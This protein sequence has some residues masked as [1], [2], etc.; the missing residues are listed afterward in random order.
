MKKNKN[1]L[2]LLFIIIM[3]NLTDAQL[4]N[5][6][7]LEFTWKTDTSRHS[8]NLSEITLVLPKGSFPK[9]DYP[10]FVGK[11][12]G[13]ERFYIH[14]P[15][16][17]VEIDGLAK[18]YPLNML[19]IHEISNDKLGGVPILATYCPLCNASVVFDRRITVNGEEKEL[20]FEVSGMLRKS[21]M[22]M[23]D[24][25]T[26]SLWQQFM[27]ESIVGEFTGT[28]L[29]VIPS[30]I[31]SLKSFFDRYPDG[32]VLS[33]ETTDKDLAGL[34][35]KNHY[36]GY[37]KE[38][39]NPFGRYFNTSDIDPRLPAMERVIDIEVK[40]SRKIYP[41]SAIAEK[42]VINDSFK[43][44]HIVFFHGGR[45][46]SVLDARQIR[47][48]RA[49]GSVTAFR[50]V[51]GDSLYTFRKSG[52]RFKDEQTGST[53]DITGRCVKGELKGTLLKIVPHSN[54]FAFAWLAF[55]PDSEIY[56]E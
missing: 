32:K 14:E 5:P 29:K 48:S 39:G 19:T 17:A 25:E 20:E 33:N 28:M 23:L 27:G 4:R 30:M 16:I 11:R 3:P 41:F 54:H 50:P 2:I 6:K 22:V 38:G 26:E 7:K 40:G 36:V 51:V 9:I 53:W 47:E 44:Y 52:N 31:I 12:W 35:G 10:G 34:Y 8:V 24:T 49:I 42:G 37:D 43:G 46:V 56:G 45:T 55:F 21:D 18:A 1:L 15:V 13:L